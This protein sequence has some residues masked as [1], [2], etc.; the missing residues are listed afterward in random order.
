MRLALLNM[1]YSQFARRAYW[2]LFIGPNPEPPVHRKPP[3]PAKPSNKCCLLLLALQVAIAIATDVP[4]ITLQ[5]DANLSCIICCTTKRGQLNIAK[6][7][8]A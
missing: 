3:D 7:T 1:S 5:E 4:P 6:L 8:S 2:S